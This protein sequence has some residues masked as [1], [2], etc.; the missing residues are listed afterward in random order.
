MNNIFNTVASAIANGLEQ[1]KHEELVAE[2]KPEATDALL[3]KGMAE[4]LH[5][6][7]TPTYVDPRLADVCD[8]SIHHDMAQ[9]YGAISAPPQQEQSFQY[10]LMTPTDVVQ[11]PALADIVHARYSWKNQQIAHRNERATRLVKM[12]EVLLN[13]IPPEASAAEFSVPVEQVIEN[14]G[15][16]VND[17]R[18]NLETAATIQFGAFNLDSIFDLLEFICMGKN[19]QMAYNAFCWVYANFLFPVVNESTPEQMAEVLE[20]AFQKEM[21]FY[22]DAVKGMMTATLFDDFELP[23][24]EE[25]ATSPSEQPA[26]LSQSPMEQFTADWEAAQN[27]VMET[28]V[29]PV[30]VD[31]QGDPL[32]TAVDPAPE[33]ATVDLDTQPVKDAQDS[34]NNPQS[35]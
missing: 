33:N 13:V 27:Q 16:L 17:L 11:V 8:Q 29:A 21:P 20:E 2:T 15:T 12:Y 10:D 4:A 30:L 1:V 35:K 28:I 9:G 7:P 6:E 26:E 34:V 32:T 22:M 31:A 23:V 24:M 18:E 25:P 14:R 19:Q 5:I 3:G